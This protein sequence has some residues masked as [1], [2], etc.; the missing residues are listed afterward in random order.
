MQK[1]TS[2]FC[3]AIDTPIFPIPS[4]INLHPISVSFQKLE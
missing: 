4:E 1:F 3:L 2:E